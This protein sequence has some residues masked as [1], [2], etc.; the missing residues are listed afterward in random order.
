MAEVT[1]KPSQDVPEGITCRRCGGTAFKTVWQQFSDG[2]RHVRADCAS[3]G[4]F[5]RYLKQPESPD[6]RFEPRQADAHGENL[7]P[8]PETWQW[9]GWIRQADEVW[10][11]IALA[12][13]LDKCWEALMHFPG[14]GD[15]LCT[16]TRAAQR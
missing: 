16:P 15:L 9:L 6:F 2:K 11:P 1:L 12:D 3:C 14:K 8:P 7:A 4:G 10:R 5:V 13:T